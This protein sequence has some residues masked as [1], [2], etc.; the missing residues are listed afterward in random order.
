[1]PAP[2]PDSPKSRAA[3]SAA[4]PCVKDVPPVRPFAVSCFAGRARNP[5]KPVPGAHP[6]PAN[7]IARPATPVARRAAPR[8]ARS[9]TLQL[10]HPEQGVGM[11]ADFVDRAQV[12]AFERRE[13]LH[14]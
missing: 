13:D 1:P 3:R 14:F 10:L 9:T 2:C 8:A 5:R 11:L 6:S 4:P 12:P 7:S